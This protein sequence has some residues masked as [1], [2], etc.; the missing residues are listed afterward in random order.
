MKESYQL[1][2]MGLRR[3]F[4]GRVVGKHILHQLGRHMKRSP[5]LT[6]PSYRHEGMA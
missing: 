3:P 4:P 2:F 6:I 1:S 5:L